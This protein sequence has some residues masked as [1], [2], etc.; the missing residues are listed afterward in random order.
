MAWNF[1]H[2]VVWRFLL[3]SLRG[4]H[5]IRGGQ[6]IDIVRL[7]RC[8]WNFGFKLGKQASTPKRLKLGRPS[9]TIIIQLG[10]PNR[11]NIDKMEPAGGSAGSFFFVANAI[12]S[13]KDWMFFKEKSIKHHPESV[14]ERPQRQNICKYVRFGLPKRTQIIPERPRA[15]P[16]HPQTAPRA[17]QSVPRACPDEPKTMRKL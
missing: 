2:R 17:S 6:P 3:R 15:F 7:G 11:P 4:D 1:H 8:D 10:D 16:D 5:R 9:L 14:P 13:D 12:K